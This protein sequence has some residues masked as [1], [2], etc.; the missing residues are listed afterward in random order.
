VELDELLATSSSWEAAFAAFER[1]RKPNTDAIAAMALENY[2]EMRS[3]V[4]DPAYVR[5]KAEEE[6][7]MRT[8]P[9]FISRYA[10]VMFHPEISFSEI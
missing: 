7:K 3:T 6:E 2:V 8:D 9:N 4:L 5:R 1:A 10:K